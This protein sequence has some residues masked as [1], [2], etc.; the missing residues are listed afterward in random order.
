[1]K[2][3]YYLRTLGL[4]IIVTALLMGFATTPKEAAAPVIQEQEIEENE[5]SVLTDL[6]Q[7]NVAKQ[8]EDATVAEETPKVEEPSAEEAQTGPIMEEETEEAIEE[9]A[10]E[11]EE[12]AAI[13]EEID[14]SDL[15]EAE[16]TP[17]ETE[18]GDTQEVIMT[19]EEAEIT[20]DATVEEPAIADDQTVISFQIQKGDSSDKVSRKL[21]DLGLVEDAKAFDRYLCSQGYDKRI[22]VGVYEIP[23]S[24]SEEEIARIIARK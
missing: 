18:I 14:E 21:Q 5:P 2:L 7:N 24:C 4:G 9:S 11:L 19:P 1:M 13:E 6:S 16:Q 8:E 22:S 15:V 23:A 20:D 17:V 12:E 10:T 3:K